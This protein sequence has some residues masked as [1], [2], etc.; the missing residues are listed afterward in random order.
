MTRADPHVNDTTTAPLVDGASAQAG[1][2][3]GHV[4]E[5]GDVSGS[6]VEAVVDLVRAAREEGRPARV[7]V[8]GVA[9]AGVS[10]VLRAA[11]AGCAPR[12][13]SA[14]VGVAVEGD[15]GM[16]R[17]LVAWLR[18]EGLPE[19]LL[20][21]D[22][23]GLARQWVRQCAHTA[24]AVLVDDLG[25]DYRWGARL[26]QWCPRGALLI[27]THLPDTAQRLA[28]AGFA[29]VRIP[30]PSGEEVHAM[31]TARS[32]A[33]DPDEVRAVSAECGGERRSAVLAAAALAAGES[34]ADV[35][36]ALGAT[37]TVQHAGQGLR[38]PWDPLVAM[39][40]GVV[41]PG[42]GDLVRRLAVLGGAEVSIEAV[43]GG[44]ESESVA[45]LVRAA[46]WAGLVESSAPGR[47]RL[48]AR[49]QRVFG[50]VTDGW[51]DLAAGQL[52]DQA[53][54]ALRAIT[55]HYLLRLAAADALLGGRVEHRLHPAYAHAAARARELFA[56]AEQARAWMLF[57]HATLT[58]LSTQLH[59]AVPA[60]APAQQFR[61]ERELLAGLSEADRA[62]RTVGDRHTWQGCTRRGLHAATAIAPH[63]AAFVHALHHVEALLTGEHPMSATDRAH[64][65]DLLAGALTTARASGNTYWQAWALWLRA[66]AHPDTAEHDLAAAHDLVAETDPE[67]AA[68]VALASARD[69]L[70]RG[71]AAL[72]VEAAEHAVGAGD[73]IGGR[74]GA[75]VGCVAA[76]L[77]ATALLDTDPAH[78]VAAA[79]RLLA[80][81]TDNTTAL[82]GNLTV[83]LSWWTHHLVATALDRG[84]VPWPVGDLDTAAAPCRHC[85]DR[86]ARD[87]A[88]AH[89]GAAR[90]LGPGWPTPLERGGLAASTDTAT[91]TATA[92]ATVSVDTRPDHAPHPVPA[93]S[94]ARR[95]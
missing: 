84:P 41:A 17:L 21:A 4:V 62:W 25:A 16:E 48:P 61:A 87:R 76:A 78:A 26:A 50:T 10:T 56:D 45:A 92:A 73:R 74:V 57:E 53:R 94:S 79:H 47:C 33:A 52:D 95:P 88:A 23:V 58:A 39:V 75:E 80:R 22:L 67:S 51:L 46:A 6:V 1:G 64:V 19:Q 68:R 90:A 91:S 12:V 11:A 43:A 7:V 86:G 89:R 82:G 81:I 65:D 72:A 83:L 60:D 20:A 66:A 9:G 18:A 8:T 49:V 37:R 63:L 24:P 85:A 40:L 38:A 14:P 3:G 31:I 27:G 55:G 54:A 13:L 71:P 59:H 5:V 2:A 69:A 28:D 77:R 34:A 32:G 29:V 42:V 35:V 30:A 15:G 70:H 36:A 93:R 44:G